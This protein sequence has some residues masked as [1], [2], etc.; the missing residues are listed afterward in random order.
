[1]NENINRQVAYDFSSCLGKGQGIECGSV[2]GGVDLS[3]QPN[4]ISVEPS[5][6][7]ILFSYRFP[8]LPLLF[9]VV[10]FRSVPYFSVPLRS[11]W[12]ISLRAEQR[13]VYKFH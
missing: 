12:W 13:L 11:M 2:A 4:L 1:M 7:L 10:A 8:S 6:Y 9:N 3:H 5:F